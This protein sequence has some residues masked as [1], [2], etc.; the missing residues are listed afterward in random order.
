MNK[1]LSELVVQLGGDPADPVWQWFIVNG[2]HGA[3]FTW[4][5][6]KKSPPGYNGLEHLQR[7]ILERSEVDPSFASRARQIAEIA[8]SSDDLDLKRRAI[9]VLAVVGD[10]EHIKNIEPYASHPAATLSKDA[11]AC[12]FELKRK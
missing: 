12:L 8:L 6:T 5:Q 7:I 2:P 10:R 11:K 4:S 1:D 9:Q 3:C